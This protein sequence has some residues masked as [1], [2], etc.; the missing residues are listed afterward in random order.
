MTERLAYR[1]CPSDNVLAC[2]HWSH[3]IHNSPVQMVPAC[4]MRR[5]ASSE[6]LI[7]LV[8]PRSRFSIANDGSVRGGGRTSLS[9]PDLN[10]PNTFTNLHSRCH[11]R[12]RRRESIPRKISSQWPALRPRISTADGI[13][14]SGGESP[15]LS[16]L[17]SM[18]R[19]AITTSTAG[20]TSVRIGKRAFLSRAQL[21]GSRSFG[22]SLPQMVP[23]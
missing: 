14:M 5:E 13:S 17:I 19:T 7:S 8:A 16:H 6:D 10:G 1:S 18:D 23:V 20:S 4:A 9:R 12:T 3:N 15:S 2:S 21:N 22:E 11:Q